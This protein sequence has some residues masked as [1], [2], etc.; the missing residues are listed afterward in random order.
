MRSASLHLSPQ[1]VVHLKTPSPVRESLIEYA[2]PIVSVGEKT[3]N[4]ASYY[5]GE[6]EARRLR[7][8]DGSPTL[9]RFNKSGKRI[10]RN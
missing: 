2:R 5:R 6:R 7:K 1:Q 10:R 3:F 4:L 9:P 8:F